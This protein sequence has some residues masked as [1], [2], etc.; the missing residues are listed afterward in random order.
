MNLLLHLDQSR[1]ISGGGYIA[2]RRLAR[3]LRGA[4]HLV[5]ETALHRIKTEGKAQALQYSTSEL[6]G[7]NVMLTS[8]SVATRLARRDARAHGLRVVAFVH[9]AMSIDH[10]LDADVVVWGSA[11]LMRYAADKKLI[12]WRDVGWRDYIMW[13]LIFPD[14]V[15]VEPLP[16]PR[17]ERITLINLSREKGAEIFYKM[18]ELAPDLQFLGVQ[19]WGPQLYWK[20]ENLPPNL[21]IIPWIQ[22]PRSIYER[23]AVLLYMK[24]EHCSDAWLNGV[25]LTAL[26]AAVSGIPTVYYPGPGLMESLQDGGLVCDSFDPEEWVKAVR[27]A[28]ILYPL[29]SQRARLLAYSLKPERQAREFITV[30]EEMLR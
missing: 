11:A 3:A 29:H 23:T 16:S 25:G 27:A 7:W 14:E 28:L 1:P 15:R 26:E 6:K 5:K 10:R 24:G 13:P 20:K 30:L 21:E 22:D 17:G 2:M 9:S 4:G 19:G 8:A 18:V 12:E